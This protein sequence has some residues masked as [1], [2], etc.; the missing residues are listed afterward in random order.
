MTVRKIATQENDVAPGV[1][2]ANDV[3]AEAAAQAPGATPSTALI[4]TTAP[5]RVLLIHF[6]DVILTKA[7]LSSKDLLKTWES[8]TCEKAILSLTSTFDQVYI[9]FKSSK[10]ENQQRV[11]EWMKHTQFIQRVH[12]AWD[13]VLFCDGEDQVQEI[14]QLLGVT[15]VIHP[16]IYKCGKY[17]GVTVVLVDWTSHYNTQLT[18]DEKKF[19]VRAN[20]WADTIE[21]LTTGNH[22]KINEV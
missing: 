16:D 4:T 6:A 11:A 17:S 14:N 7:K 20:S 8:E 21:L 12:L 2:S 9:L 19:V 22:V 5:K 10:K 3:L 18:P 15:H 1:M 13:R